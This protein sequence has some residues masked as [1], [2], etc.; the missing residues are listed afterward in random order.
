MN[1]TIDDHNLIQVQD[2]TYLIENKQPLTTKSMIINILDISLTNMCFFFCVLIQQ[3]I[4]LIFISHTTK[5]EDVKSAIEAIGISHLYVNCTL[6]SIG[7]GLISG[8]E[9]LGSNSFGMKNYKLL[10]IYYQRA[11]IVGFTFTF[12]AIIVHFFCAVPILRNFISNEVIIF[13]LDKYIHILLFFVLFDVQYS[14]NTRYLNVIGKFKINLLVLVITTPL[15]VLW[16]FLLIQVAQLGI[17]GAAVALILSQFLNAMIGSLYIVVFKPIPESV[18]C[19]SKKS[20]TGLWSYFKFALPSMFLLCAEWWAFE[21]QAVIAYFVSELDYTAQ[22]ILINME[23]IIFSI[24]IGFASSMVTL[25]G[26]SISEDV[27]VTKKY[28]KLTLLIA[29]SIILVLL[30]LL[31]IFKGSII[32]LFISNQPDVYDKIYNTIIFV[33]TMNIFD[34]LQFNLGFA[35]RGLRKQLIASIFAFVNFYCIQTS[36]SILLGIVADMKIQGVWLGLT[37]G[38]FGSACVYSVILWNIDFEKIKNETKKNINQ[39]EHDLIAESEN[40]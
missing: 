15:H 2:E 38:T 18:F 20:F 11:Q 13:Y 1:D 35:L 30:T 4:N 27:R 36:A 12:L 22:V 9:T 31:Y 16:C 5:K 40:I 26:Q 7:V 17:E 39:D 19:Y 21:I 6:L 33:C 29:F 24:T 37:I 23:S 32:K 28:I 34:V 10:G 8:F 25:V 3:S 14:L